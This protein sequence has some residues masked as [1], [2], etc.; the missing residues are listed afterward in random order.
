MGGTHSISVSGGL[1]SKC[2][3]QINDT[4]TIT[5]FVESCDSCEIKYENLISDVLN[6]SPA[7]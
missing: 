1:Q 7:P 6:L 2:L 5:E 4:R 3:R